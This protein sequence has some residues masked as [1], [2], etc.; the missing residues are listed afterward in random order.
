MSTYPVKLELSARMEVV[1]IKVTDKVIPTRDN[2]FGFRVLEL[3]TNLNG[4]TE[5]QD[6]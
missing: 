2:H 6:I 5:S 3:F 4:D 1:M